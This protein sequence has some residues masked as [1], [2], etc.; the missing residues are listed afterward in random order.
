MKSKDDILLAE[1]VE[2]A[3]TRYNRIEGKRKHYEKFLENLYNEN[4][5][6]A[7][8]TVKDA[9]NPKWEDLFRIERNKWQS[10]GGFGYDFK[11]VDHRGVRPFSGD[12][13][14]D[15]GTDNALEFMKKIKLVSHAAEIIAKKK[16]DSERHKV[17]AIAHYNKHIKGTPAE[18]YTKN[19]ETGNYPYSGD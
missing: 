13:S 11:L 8:Y 19:P 7:W 4:G 1:A 5:E 3:L 10:A 2:D 9:K 15:S 18:Y 16:E 6:N 17:A 14:K 12:L